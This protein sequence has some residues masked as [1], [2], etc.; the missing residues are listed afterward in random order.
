[1]LDPT[2]HARAFNTDTRPPTLPVTQKDDTSQSALERSLTS[3]SS[4]L[5]AP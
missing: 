2:S 1:M 5:F 4:Y 3:S